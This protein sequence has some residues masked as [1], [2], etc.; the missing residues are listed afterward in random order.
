M[1]EFDVGACFDLRMVPHAFF[2]AIELQHGVQL[3][4]LLI[5]QKIFPDAIS[6]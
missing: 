5:F 2:T 6:S 3:V 4:V 1:F